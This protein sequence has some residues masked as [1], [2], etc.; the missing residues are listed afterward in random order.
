MPTAY[1]EKRPS[2]NNYD[3][4]RKGIQNRINEIDLSSGIMSTIISKTH[5]VMYGRVQID[6]GKK[7]YKLISPVKRAQTTV[8]LENV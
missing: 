7:G 6:R 3:R 1:D 8:S 2:K 5:Y 4:L